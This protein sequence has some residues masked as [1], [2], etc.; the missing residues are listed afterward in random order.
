MRL[1]LL[2]DRISFQAVRNPQR[3]MTLCDD[4]LRTVIKETN[5][6]ASLMSRGFFY[7]VL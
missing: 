5:A 1:R 3:A 6:D 7:A 2:D 4:F